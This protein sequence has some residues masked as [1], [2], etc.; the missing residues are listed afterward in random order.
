MVGR[1]ATCIDQS[2]H[3]VK[4]HVAIAKIISGVLFCCEHGAVKMHWKDTEVTVVAVA[5]VGGSQAQ[6]R[7]SRQ[8]VCCASA[9]G[10]RDQSAAGPAGGSAAACKGKFPGMESVHLIAA[11]PWYTTL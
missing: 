6:G 7:P 8:P 4:M 11:V 10:R 2:W 1:P 9:A 5:Q 3:T